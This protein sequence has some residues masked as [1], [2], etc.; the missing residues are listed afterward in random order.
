M[1]DPR[2][3]T[4][5]GKARYWLPIKPGTDIALLLAWMHV[6]I[7]EKRYDTDY[8]DKHAVG[9]D[10]LKQHVADKTPEWAYAVTG[11]RAELI[12]RDG[13]LHRRLP[14]RLAD[15]SGPP[16]DLVRRRHAAGARH[17]HPGSAAGQLGPSRRLSLARRAWRSPSFPTPKYAYEPKRRRTSQPVSTPWPTRRWPRACATPRFPAR[18][19]N[20]I[21]A[22]MV[23]GTNLIQALPNPKQTQ[24]AIQ[25][26]DFIVSIDVLPA[27]ICGWSDVVLPE[28]TY[29]ERCD[30]VWAPA[31]K[32]PFLAVRQPVVEPMYDSKPG[33][34]IARELAQRL[35]LEDYFPWKDSIEYAEQRVKAAGL[36]CDVL[37]E[38]GVV[39]GEKTPVCEEEGLELAFGTSS[40]KIELYSETLKAAGF[41][42]LPEFTPPEEPPPGMFRLLFGRAPV[43]T[44]GRTTNNRFLSQVFNENEVWMNE[45]ALKALPQF[46]NQEPQEW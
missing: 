22:W 14:T 1:V 4:A 13:S 3:S 21:K 28:C 39:L 26:L 24:R 5:A 11:I 12:V 37:K 34:W 33:W 9:F 23:Y 36:D 18:H 6:I 42:P 8:I 27:E 15:P 10:E 40:G 46:A 20:P 7:N 16:R 45:D 38:T 2:F 25:E 35:G 44:F 17:G 31:Y 41:H 29:L 43:H 30:E 19:A 32:Q